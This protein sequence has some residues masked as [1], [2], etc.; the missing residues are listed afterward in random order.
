MGSHG[1]AGAFSEA[2]EGGEEGAAGGGRGA[3][4]QLKLLWRVDSLEDPSVAGGACGACFAGEDDGFCGL[5]G[6]CTGV[7]EE[8]DGGGGED[9]DAQESVFLCSGGRRRLFGHGNGGGGG[10]GGGRGQR[11]RRGA[12]SEER[13]RGTETAE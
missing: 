2:D 8:S 4:E 11:W 7:E 3:E 1:V 10:G 13:R 5:A 9:A 12:V 6:T